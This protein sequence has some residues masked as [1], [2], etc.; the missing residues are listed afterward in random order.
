MKNKDQILKTCIESYGNTNGVLGL[1]SKKNSQTA[2]QI[3]C[4]VEFYTLLE[5]V[6]ID[7]NSLYISGSPEDTNFKQGVYFLKNK[8]LVCLDIEPNT[9]QYAT[10]WTTG[11]IRESKHF[12]ECSGSFMFTFDFIDN[13]E[14]ADI[15][16]PHIYSYFVID[17]CSDEIVPIL[18]MTYLEEFRGNLDFVMDGLNYLLETFNFNINIDKVKNNITITN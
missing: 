10:Y 14:M 3:P 6:L 13:E 12:T 15:F 5:Q 17:K 1:F 11:F 4:L 7:N 16:L 2:N 18:S 9:L 8:M